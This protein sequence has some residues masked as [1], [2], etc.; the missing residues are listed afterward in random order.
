MMNTSIQFAKKQF[1]EAS[2]YSNNLKNIYEVTKEEVEDIFDKAFNNTNF[3]YYKFNGK[4]AV[5]DLV[6]GN[7]K[8]ELS[9][10]ISLILLYPEFEKNLR[11]CRLTIDEFGLCP[12]MSES[13]T[14]IKYLKLNNVLELNR[15]LNLIEDISLDAL[16]L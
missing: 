2:L 14:G 15:F 7:V 11:N 12:I 1:K 10:M 13:F 6:T 9:D 8:H 3:Q 4:Q 16:K 5:L